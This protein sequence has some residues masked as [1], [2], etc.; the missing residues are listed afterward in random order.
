[1][2]LYVYICQRCGKEVEE[3]QKVDDPPPTYD[4]PQ[5]GSC[6]ME[7]QLSCPSFKF[8]AGDTEGGG[9]E[10]QGDLMIRQVK[11]KNTS[12]YGDGSV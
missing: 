6:A 2:P 8:R 7:K 1:M 12:R 9:W 10:R 5:G 3:L 11:G 4:C